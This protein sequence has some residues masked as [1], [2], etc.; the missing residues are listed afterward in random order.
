MRYR[1]RTTTRSSREE[2]SMK[3]A[4]ETVS[5]GKL[6]YRKAA[7]IFNIPKDA[8]HRKLIRS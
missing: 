6:S 8:L 7:D 1:P 2:C 3:E 5:G 4:M